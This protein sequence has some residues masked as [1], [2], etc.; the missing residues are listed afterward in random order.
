MLPQIIPKSLLLT[1]S[2]QP[3]L[4]PAQLRFTWLLADW[5]IVCWICGFIAFADMV[6]ILEKL[7]VAAKQKE[8]PTHQG[9]PSNN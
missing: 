9:E 3:R 1:L 4:V 7:D 6:G 2:K 5:L 8:C